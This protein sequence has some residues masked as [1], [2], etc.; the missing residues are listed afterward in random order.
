[1][2]CCVGCDVEIDQMVWLVPSGKEW[3]S[4]LVARDPYLVMVIDRP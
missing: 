3:A 2:L 1:M 4:G